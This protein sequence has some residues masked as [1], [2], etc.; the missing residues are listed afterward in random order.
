MTAEKTRKTKTPTQMEVAQRAQV[1]RSLVSHVLRGRTDL[2]ISEET[3]QRVLRAAAEL[4]YEARRQYQ[5]QR[6]ER[7]LA[8]CL[9]GGVL[10]GFAN[11]FI[12]EVLA[13]ISEAALTADYHL[14]LVNPREAFTDGRS[15]PRAIS[16]RRVQGI[17]YLSQMPQSMLDRL[18]KLR[19]PV[20]VAGAM[21]TDPRADCVTSDGYDEGTLAVDFLT[22]QGHRRIALLAGPSTAILSHR[23]SEGFR[24]RMQA[25]GLSP[26]RVIEFP[27]E[28]GDEIDAAAGRIM[29][30]RFLDRRRHGWQDTTALYCT[31]DATAMGAL[32][33]L[34]REGIRVPED[35]SVLGTDNIRGSEHTTPPLTTIE[36]P[37]FQIGSLATQRL[38]SRIENPSQICQ[39]II[40][41]VTLIERQSVRKLQG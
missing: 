23:Q 4:A 6:A 21:T 12:A 29:A 22:A 39:R 18:E 36:V 1:S 26:D 7:M 40:L 16:Q 25:K 38:I 35:L 5:P 30:E 33:V 19:E 20:V 13:G 31:N 37:K 28:A 41:P 3:R 34:R 32:E 14:L 2:G 27:A 24:E 10:H 17:I 9:G 11:P 15:V 8:L